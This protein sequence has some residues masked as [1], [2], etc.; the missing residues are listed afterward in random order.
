MDELFGYNQIN[1]LPANQHKTTLVFPWGLFAYHKLPFGLKNA[2]A[3]FQSAMEYDFHDTK[4]TMQPYLD[5]FHAHSIHCENHPMHLR[6][7]FLHYRR[8]K[9]RLNP[10]KNVIFFQF[11]R[12]IGFIV[13]NNAIHIDPMKVQEIIDFP[14]PSSLV[15]LQ[16]HQ[17]NTNFLLRFIPNYVKLMKIFTRLMKKR[18]TF[19]WDHTT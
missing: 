18:V 16:C 5:G 1:I 3:T 12:L 4:H 19:H 14:A 6:A 17:G 8:Y 11:S 9:I 2:G 15:Q 13:L 10:K 7:I